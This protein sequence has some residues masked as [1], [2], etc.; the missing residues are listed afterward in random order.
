MKKLIIFF[1]AILLATASFAQYDYDRDDRNLDTERFHYKDDFDWRWDIRVRISNGLT[2]G[3]LTNREARRL[4]NRLERI[5]RCEYDFQ[6]DGYYSGRE[7]D[8][9]WD[10][11]MDL[12]RRIG[13]ELSDWDRSYYGYSRPGYAYRGFLNYYDRGFYDFYRF[14]KWG[15]GSISLGY[16]PRF[17]NPPFDRS[18]HYH[19]RTYSNRNNNNYRNLRPN[20][21]APRHSNDRK[22]KND[23]DWDRNRRGQD[24]DYGYN[25]ERNAERSSSNSGR[26]ETNTN[27]RNSRGS[28]ISKPRE[29]RE[30]IQTPRR[31]NN[32]G[33]RSETRPSRS[34]REEIQTPR[35]ENNSGSRSETRPS[36]SSR[37]E[38]QT[39]RG[40]RQRAPESDKLNDKGR[41]RNNE[42]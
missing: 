25:N 19:Y 23:G 11:V 42:F 31:E 39:P 12:H 8:E 15:W 17:Y 5:E 40:S 26:S 13:I 24:R 22:S 21:N 2:N 29:N 36:R 34:S 3:N 16:R 28:E 6:R 4:Y 33:S 32:S 7:Q 35:R 10:D 1:G 9:V 37:E 20:N 30:E 41:G 38:I 18:Y 14:D 27:S